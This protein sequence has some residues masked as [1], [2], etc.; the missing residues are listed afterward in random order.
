MAQQGSVFVSH[1]AWYVRYR[2]PEKQADGTV[3]DVQ[4]AKRLASKRDYPKK[5]EVIP[6]KNEFMT[7]LN[8]T[9]FT[10]EAGV[11]LVTFVEDSYFPAIEKRLSPSTVR[12]YREAWRCHLKERV[13]QFRVRDFRTV[14]GEHLMSE[15]EREHG[16]GL[17][18]GTYK[19]I[20]VTLSAIFT[21]ARRQGLIDGVN[22]MQG[23]SIPKGRRHGRK[24]LAYSLEEIQQHLRLF[25]TDE[26]LVITKKNASVYRPELAAKVVGGIIGTASFAGLREGELRGLWWDDDDGEVLNIQ[27]SVW[28]TQ[29]K[30]TKTGEDEEDAG[31]V[32]II[33][34]LRVLLDAIR[35]ENAYGFVFA[36]SI[37]GSLDLDNLANRVI[38]PMLK[39][40]GLVWK[41]WHAYRRGLATNLKRLGVDDN[42]IQAILRHEDIGTTQSSYIKMARP[43]VTAAM[44]SLEAKVQ[45]AAVVQQMVN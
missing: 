39:A 38:K 28:R 3:V 45:C 9:R 40:N 7:K 44:K 10:P 23:V 30:D 20:K 19:W 29:M 14:D 21:F 6:L 5:S 41:G 22:P 27:R 8:R 33:Q 24:R 11:S 31:V 17:A 1:G 32:P 16:T 25:S 15:L 43:D 4:H 35:P 2:I 12:G 37:G 34:P 26:L 36:N 13:T 42:V 18:H